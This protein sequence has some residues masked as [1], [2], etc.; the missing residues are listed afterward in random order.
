M[1]P[2]LFATGNAGKARELAALLAHELK[3]LDVR[4]LD[5]RDGMPSQFLPGV[6]RCG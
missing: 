1:K 2:L 5:A 3:G 4:T 6:S